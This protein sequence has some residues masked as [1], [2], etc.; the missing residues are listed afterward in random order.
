ME[1]GLDYMSMPQA[2]NRFIADDK[3]I[4]LVTGTHG[5]TTTSAIMAHLLE[6]CRS[7]PFIYDRGD[8]KGL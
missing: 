2:V 8:F 6:Y 7:F 4:I 5:K 3:K 1:R